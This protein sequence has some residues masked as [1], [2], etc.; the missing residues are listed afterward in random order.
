MTAIIQE[1]DRLIRGK[2]TLNPTDII[3]VTEMDIV[4]SY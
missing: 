1:F 2:P 3:T 4:Q